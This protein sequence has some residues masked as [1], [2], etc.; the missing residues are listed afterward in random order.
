MDTETDIERRLRHDLAGRAADI[1]AAPPS[2]YD[3][4]LAGARRQRRT[5]AT[6][7]AVG[8]CALAA[9]LVLPLGLRGG[10]PAAP[11]GPGG[12]SATAAQAGH[13]SWDVAPRG[14]LAGDRAYLDGL[15]ARPWSSLREAAGPPGE[16]RAV[17]FA[18][19]VPGGVAALV[20]GRQDGGWTGLWLVGEAGQAPEG[21]RAAGEAVPVDPDR[22]VSLWHTGDGAGALVVVSRPGDVV[23][24][25]PR[26]GA[27]YAVVGDAEGVAVVDATTLSRSGF[28]VRV[29]RDGQEVDGGSSVGSQVGGGPGDVDVAGAVG[30]AAGDPDPRLVHLVVQGLL[31]RSDLTTADVDVDVRWGGPIGTPQRPDAVAV[32]ATVRLPSGDTVLLGAQGADDVTSVAPCLRTLLPAGTAVPPL[33]AMRCDLHGSTDGAALGSQLV[34]VVPEGTATVSL[35]GA[36]GAVLGTRPAGDGEVSVGPAPEGVASVTALDAAGTVL[37]TSAVGGVEDVV[38]D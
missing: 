31:Q 2:L 4:V 35:T 23:E 21:L 28:D 7:L 24:V 17:A 18:G 15:L 37:A 32:V 29:T 38:L 12:T 14:S 3:D 27:P 10:D 22:P 13:A 19:A 9:A 33:V 11:A 8:A 1:G 34:V 30:G 16:T 25:S 6:A 5:R 26:A 36:S 20:V